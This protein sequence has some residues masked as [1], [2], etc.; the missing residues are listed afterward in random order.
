[1]WTTWT[2]LPA[3][4]AVIGGLVTWAVVVASIVTR[5]RD[6]R[7]GVGHA[8]GQHRAGAHRISW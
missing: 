1:M 2:A 7:D 3:V 5:L 4:L 6:R 8:R